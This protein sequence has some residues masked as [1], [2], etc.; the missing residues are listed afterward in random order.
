MIADVI[1]QSQKIE[2]TRLDYYICRSGINPEYIFH[3][4][5]PVFKKRKSNFLELHKK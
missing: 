3:C 2:K 1:G 5:K 4:G